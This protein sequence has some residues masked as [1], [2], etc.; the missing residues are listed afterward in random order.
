MTLIYFILGLSLL[1]FVHEL[2]HFIFAKIFNVYVYEFS[3]FMGPVVYQK[4][5]GETRYSLRL[6]PIGGYVAMAGE[7][8]QQAAMFPNEAPV[9]KNR[10]INGIKRW[11]KFIILVAGATFNIIFAI[12]LLIAYFYGTGV[13]DNSNRIRVVEDSIFYQ[14]GLRSDDQIIAMRGSL[15]TGVNYQELEITSFEQVIKVINQTNPIATDFNGVGQSQCFDISVLRNQQTLAFNNVCRTFTKYDVNNQFQVTAVEPLLGIGQ[16]TRMVNPLE[17][18]QLAVATTGQMSLLIYNSLGQLFAPGGLDNVAGPVGM[19]YSAVSFADAGLLAFIFF[20][21][22]I[23]V[24]LGVINLLPFPALDGGQI[25]I[26]GVE[27]LVGKK[28]SPKL[29]AIINGIGFM[30]LMTFIVLITIRDIFFR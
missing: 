4:K 17:A 19:Y 23:S 10:T 28:L 6:L 20:I 27:K 5:I 3:M 12:L 2:G 18:S 15:T 25:L 1:I 9:E 7:Q 8:N 16:A 21:A 24:N 11:Q 14:A 29:E 26:L 22:L 30:I 13:A